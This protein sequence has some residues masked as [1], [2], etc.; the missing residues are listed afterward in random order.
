[1]IIVILIAF[2]ISIVVIQINYT[3]WANDGNFEFVENGVVR[4]GR[5]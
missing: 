5:W 3:R 4:Q 2:F 1:M